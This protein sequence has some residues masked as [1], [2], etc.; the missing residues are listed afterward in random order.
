VGLQK[1]GAGLAVEKNALFERGSGFIVTI[2]AGQRDSDAVQRE[3]LVDA[4]SEPP[5]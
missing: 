5:E 1:P 3:T 2:E 4:I